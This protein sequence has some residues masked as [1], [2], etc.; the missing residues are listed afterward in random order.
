MQAW[1]QAGWQPATADNLAAPRSLSTL[2]LRLPLSNLG[3]TTWER[4]LEVTPW[5]VGEVDLYQLDTAGE[6]VLGHWH[7]G[8]SVPLGE[9]SVHSRRNL[10]PVKLAPGEERQLLL[11]VRS[12]SRPTLALKSST[13][14]GARTPAW[15]RRSRGAPRSC[16]RRCSRPRTPRWRRPTSSPGSAT[17]CAR[18]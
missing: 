17:T 3:A 9:R 13:P 7:I 18:R 12:E 16:R 2:W 5:R 1:H 4:W 11:R 6:Q 10:L 8:M 14:S 15:K